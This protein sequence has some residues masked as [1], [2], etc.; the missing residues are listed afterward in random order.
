MTRQWTQASV[1][2]LLTGALV[3]G[4]WLAGLHRGYVADRPRLLSGS[5]WLASNQVGQLTLLDGSSAEVAAQ[6]QVAAPGE[7]FDV[8]QHLATG[9]A[10]NRSTGTIRRVDGAN[11]DVSPPASPLPRTGDGLRAF[12]DVDALYA[13]DTARGILADADPVTLAARG[14]SIPLAT[15]ISPQ[16]AALDEAGRLWIL[17]TATGG[18]V[19]IDRGQRHVRPGTAGAGGLLV[20][21]NGRPVV[22]DP[23][24]AVATVLDPRTGEPRTRFGVDLRPDDQ[25]QVS[26]SPHDDRVYLVA[27]RGLLEICTLTVGHCTSAVPLGDGARAD[28][29]AAVETGGRLF[30]PDYTAGRVWIVDLGSFQVVAQPQILT[31][32][33]RF[34]L[35]TRDG[36]VF[37]N[38]PDSE[39][40]GVIRL[41]GGVRPVAK[42]DPKD[43]SKGLTGV[44]PSPSARPPS[45]APPTVVPSTPAGPTVDNPPS[46]TPNPKPSPTLEPPTVRIVVSTATPLAGDDVVLQANGRSG[47]P[48]PVRARWDFGDGGGADGTRTTHQ[49]A[50]ARTYQVSVRATFADGRSAVAALSIRVGRPP[51]L[52][53]RQPANGTVSGGGIACPPTCVRTFRPGDRVAL[54]AQPAGG[55]VFFGWG[56]AC[57][58]T[59]ACALTMTGDL[60]VSATFGRRFTLTVAEPTGGSVTGPGINCPGTCTATF[61]SGQ[62]VTLTARPDGDSFLFWEG[63]CSGS[64]PTCTLT[65]N[66]NKSVAA[67]FGFI[68]PCPPVC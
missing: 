43:P 39:K 42:Y 26:G 66:G 49:W 28:L 64:K 44:D 21:A 6:V 60:T 19:W 41:D 13:L 62:R 61:N 16:A 8:V 53:V 12:V 55:F 59:G 27:A 52:T 51:V 54:T 36:V 45:S 37:F 1:S 57:R 11:F 34:Q 32:R 22:I 68:D 58:G 67:T 5:A 4:V 40:A 18:L 20:L 29:G 17:D 30:I 14:A 7:R 25:V 3:G 35:L 10:V 38:D 2:V 50:T 56:G 48:Q 46:P 15:Q 31:P 65:M 24:H 33:T 47:G 63:D 9:Y 23:V